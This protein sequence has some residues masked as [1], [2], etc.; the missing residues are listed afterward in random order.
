MGAADEQP[1]DPK[2][3][4]LRIPAAGTTEPLAIAFP[5]PLDH[6]LLQRLLWVTDAKGRKLAG[7]VA[8]SAEETRWQFTPEKPWTAGT[9]QLMVD[10]SLED[11]AGNRVGEKFE[12]DVLKPIQRTTE[13]KVMQLPFVVGAKSA[14]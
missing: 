3:W 7:V 2:T 1:I 10:T 14:R 13:A 4:K 11:L 6:A 5:K 12:V 9:Y 8:V